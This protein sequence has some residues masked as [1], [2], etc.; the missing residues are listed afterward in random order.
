M[1]LITVV[2]C[3]L[4]L[5]VCGCR[6]SARD[7]AVLALLQQGS[8]NKLRNPSEKLVRAILRDRAAAA[9]VS[10]VWL[11]HIDLTDP[12]WSHLSELS[13][14]EGLVAMH[15]FSTQ[16]TDS[17]VETI[18]AQD[19]LKQLAFYETD[20]TATGLGSVAKMSQLEQLRI[21]SPKRRIPASA[22]SQLTTLKAL[23]QLHLASDAKLNAGSLESLFRG[24]QVTVEH[25]PGS[26]WEGQ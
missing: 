14:L 11:T 15:L 19:Q 21:E 16:N 20:L 13:Q 7:E 17:F 25:V 23:K 1:R 12:A 8:M 6:D 4:S 10:E 26:L 22:L 3:M 18:P 9:E 24:C 2:L 5:L